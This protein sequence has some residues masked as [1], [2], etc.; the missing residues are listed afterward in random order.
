MKKFVFIAIICLDL[1]FLK[2]QA[3]NEDVNGEPMKGLSYETR[4]DKKH[5]IH[6]LKI[7]PKYYQIELVKAR[8]QVLGRET[9]PSMA[10]RTG[11]IAAINGG[12]FEIQDDARPSGTLIINNECFSLSKGKRALLMID[13]SHLEMKKAEVKFIASVEKKII[14]YDLINHFAKKDKIVLYNSAWGPKTLTPYKRLEVLIDNQGVITEI[15]E[16]GNNKIPNE[17]FVLSLPA[18]HP[19]KQ[20]LVPGKKVQ[21]KY[22][23]NNASTSIKSMVMGI[24]LLISQSKINPALEKTLQKQ[25]SMQPHARTALGKDAKGNIIMVVAEHVYSQSLG[26]MSIEQIQAL[27]NAKYSKKE[28][29]SK[30]LP[31]ITSDLQKELSKDSPVIGLS[32]TALAKLMLDLGCV[33]AI[34]MDGGGSSTLFLNGKVMNTVVGDEDEGLGQ[35]SLRPVSDAIVVLKRNATK[36]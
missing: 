25:F 33:E 5:I 21:F 23:V 31:K 27:L 26:K 17:G 13:G 32:L 16:T 36:P 15:A 14:A 6:I 29:N 12:F 30:T 19:L 4:K 8:D 22:L 2:A 20:S 35:R 18:N 34:N 9:V 24:P 11:A 10:I 1:L 28:Q 3:S 7:D